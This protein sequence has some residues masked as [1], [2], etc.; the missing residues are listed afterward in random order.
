MRFYRELITGLSVA[1]LLGIYV[2]PA[3]CSDYSKSSVDQLIDGLTQIDSQ[4]PGINSAAVYEGFIAAIH[5]AHFGWVF[6]ELL[7]PKFRRR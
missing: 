1:C 3:I 6:W 5:P 7:R 4:S 2:T